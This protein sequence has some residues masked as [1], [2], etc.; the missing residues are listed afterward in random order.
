MDPSLRKLDLTTDLRSMLMGAFIFVNSNVDKDTVH[1]NLRL[2]HCLDDSLDGSEMMSR[3][4]SALDTVL[5]ASLYVSFGSRVMKIT[6]DDVMLRA[7]SYSSEYSFKRFYYFEEKLAIDD[8]LF[9]IGDHR[10]LIKYIEDYFS[11]FN[12]QDPLPKT[13]V[14]DLIFKVKSNPERLGLRLI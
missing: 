5:G 13:F 4:N 11:S 12:Y 3:F 9:V 10:K 2:T 6:S 7:R 8:K 1:L 14:D